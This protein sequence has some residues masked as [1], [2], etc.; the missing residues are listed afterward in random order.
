MTTD[1]AGLPELVDHRDHSL[2]VPTPD[3]FLPLLS[4]AGAA[5]ASGQTADVLVEGP[6][7]GSLTMTAFTAGLGPLDTGDAGAPPPLPNPTTSRPRP[8]T[9]ERVPDAGVAARSRRRHRR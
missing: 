5:S 4:V 6:T 8:P 3:H 1:P 2:A 7:M 9:P